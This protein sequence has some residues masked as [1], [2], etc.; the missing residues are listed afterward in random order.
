VAVKRSK[1]TK[2]MS[3][4][5]GMKYCSN[6]VLMARIHS[7]CNCMQYV[8]PGGL[9][10]ATPMSLTDLDAQTEQGIGKALIIH[11]QVSYN[12]PDSP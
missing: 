10:R 3:P 1:Y 4:V 2:A 8:A 9:A 12:R 5:I 11:S 7:V 6:L